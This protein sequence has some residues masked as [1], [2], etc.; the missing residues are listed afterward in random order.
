MTEAQSTLP[1]QERAAQRTQR[2]TLLGI[3]IASALL[4]GIQLLVVDWLNESVAPAPFLVVFTA[5]A[6][7]GLGWAMF[8]GRVLATKHS[9]RHGLQ[10]SFELYRGS[11]LALPGLSVVAFGGIL[12]DYWYSGGVYLCAVGGVIFFAGCVVG[13]FGRPR[14]LLPRPLREPEASGGATPGA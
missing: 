13:T 14:R 5:Y 2:D 9:R 4:A 3:G 8:T 10:R 1:D 6:L 7:A 12:T 11:V